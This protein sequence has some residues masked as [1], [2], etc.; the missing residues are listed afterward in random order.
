M[1]DDDERRWRQM[2]FIL[3]HQAKFSADIEELKAADVRAA[4]RMER[5]ERVLMV[6]IRAGQRE[7]RVWREKYDALVDA[8]IRSEDAARRGQ[9]IT[10]RNSADIA[11]LA[12]IV[13]DL[14]TKQNGNGSNGQA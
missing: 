6:V 3:E 12:G 11:A 9:E 10:H 14:A 1:S 2:D 13:R 7:R 8:Q 5:L 4:R